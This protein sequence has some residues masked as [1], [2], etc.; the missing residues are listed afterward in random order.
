ML[1]AGRGESMMKKLTLVL[2][3]ILLVVG[4][5]VTVF[6][7]TTPSTVPRDMHVPCPIQ[8]C[9]AT[10]MLV[11]SITSGPYTRTHR[12]GGLFTQLCAVVYMRDHW[13]AT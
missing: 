11:Q 7:L 4:S 10:A 8:N 13:R 6:A 2:A 12:P 9:N 1:F 5:T 3:L